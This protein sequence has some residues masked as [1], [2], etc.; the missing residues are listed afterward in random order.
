M[1]F[2][3]YTYGKTSRKN[4]NRLSLYYIFGAITAISFILTTTFLLTC[5]ST[6]MRWILAG[7]LFG[8]GILFCRFYFR[9]GRGTELFLSRKI[10]DS[11]LKNAKNA[12]KPSDIFMLGAMSEMPELIFTLPLYVILALSIGNFTDPIMRTSLGIVAVMASAFPFLLIWG[13]FKS[14]RN[15]AEIQRLRVKN[16]QFIRFFITGCYL[17]VMALLIATETVGW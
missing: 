11:L 12:K 2:Y 13:F 17:I 5:G 15:L 14:G 10:A 7:I 8:V 6:L 3:H 4:A 16:K 1:L 9:K